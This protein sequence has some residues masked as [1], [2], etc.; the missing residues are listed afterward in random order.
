MTKPK[1]LI[2][3]AT[4]TNRDHDIFD[5]LVLAGAE[6][7]IVPLN[8]LKA[9]QKSWSDYQIL[10]LPGGFS[11][12]DALGAG[13][14]LAIDLNS[15]FQDQLNLFNE[16]RKAIIGVCNG[17]QALVKSGILPG[18][19]S[20]RSTLTF[21]QCGH[22]E[23]RWT[24]IKPISQKC[25]WTRNIDK[26]IEC[27]VAHGEGNFQCASPNLINELA[28]NE[29]IALVYTSPAGQKAAGEYPYNPNGSVEDI[30]GMCNEYG[31]VL[32][33]MPHPENH[34]HTYQH[35][36]WTRGEKANSGLFLFTNGVAYAS[37]L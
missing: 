3:L 20:V 18:Q 16:K 25:I 32:G 28:Q 7:E 2:L 34:I 30:A 8:I 12:A 24:T 17:F 21:N 35:P 19:K 11:Y 9:H 1:A 23:C 6:P 5:A 37:Q 26:L 36:Q 13:R 14:L 4:G 22:F 27:P 31:N 15:Y 10:A 29:Q 33:L